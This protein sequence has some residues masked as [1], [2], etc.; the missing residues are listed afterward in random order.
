[1]KQTSHFTHVNKSVHLG[2]LFNNAFILVILEI[3][4]TSVCVNV[5]KYINPGSRNSGW[6]IS[7]SESPIFH[8]SLLL[9]LLFILLSLL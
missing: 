8:N 3:L 6:R 1:M 5:P 4:A 2:N 9:L 7:I